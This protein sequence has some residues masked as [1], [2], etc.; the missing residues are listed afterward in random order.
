MIRSQQVQLQQLQQQQQQQ[1]QGQTQGQGQ[2][3]QTPST[4]TS[5]AV[6]DS[7]SSSERSTPFPAIPAQPATSRPPTQLS[8]SLS[9]RRPSRP[10]SQTTSPNLRPLP[11]SSESSRGAEGFEWIAG[12]G[13]TRGRRESRDENAYYQAE[14][15]SLSRE[16]QML[17]HRIRDLGTSSALDCVCPSV[18]SG[19]IN[20]SERQIN[21][22][23]TTASAAQPGAAPSSDPP[24][25]EPTDK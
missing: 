15:S 17:R 12:P 22:L 21:D 23:T 16:N 4:S 19:L 24:A 1:A 11:G 9:S 14:A 6:E 13:E 7:T 5:T 10:S 8:S 2:Q 25:S 20:Q 18:R 3:Q